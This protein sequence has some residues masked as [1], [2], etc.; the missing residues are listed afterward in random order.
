LSSV[1]VGKGKGRFLGDK[2]TIQRA[3]YESESGVRALIIDLE[4]MSLV[5]C[6]DD[7]MIVFPKDNQS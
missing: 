6:R 1:E 5:Q 7:E 4:K 2:P 3:L